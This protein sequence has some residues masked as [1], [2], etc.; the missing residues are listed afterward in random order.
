MSTRITSYNVCYTK[1]LRASDGK[2]S[3][4]GSLFSGI[5]LRKPGGK[6][7]NDDVPVFK[8]L[9][10]EFKSFSGIISELVCTIGT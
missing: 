6:V 8:E 9:V 4:I 2:V 3:E 10:D 5:K 7:T 1:L